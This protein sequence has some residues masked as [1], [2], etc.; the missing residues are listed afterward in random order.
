MYVS[1]DNNRRLASYVSKWVWECARGDWEMAT[2]AWGEKKAL[3]ICL[4]ANGGGGARGAACVF[5]LLP[6]VYI[7]APPAR[8]SPPAAAG[9]SGIPSGGSLKHQEAG[10]A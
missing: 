1:S 4:L 7:C 5:R 2:R 9:S 6:L 3:F 8:T 10:T